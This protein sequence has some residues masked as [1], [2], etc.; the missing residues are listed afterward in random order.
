MSVHVGSAGTPIKI[1]SLICVLDVGLI[2]TRVTADDA[3]ILG[4]VCRMSWI[5]PLQVQVSSP[6]ESKEG[7]TKPPTT[8]KGIIRTMPTK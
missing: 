7:L 1:A 2:M 4:C 6:E 5:M 3:F 8:I